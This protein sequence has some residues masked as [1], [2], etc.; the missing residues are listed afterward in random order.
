MPRKTK[1]EIAREKLDRIV[2]IREYLK[3]RWKRP[4]AT[5]EPRFQHLN[6]RYYEP[7]LAEVRKRESYK[8][9]KFDHRAYRAK[10]A[11]T[12]SADMRDA[13]EYYHQ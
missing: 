9:K 2:R 10:C 6:G 1:L 5:I 12:V 13:A 8:N 11:R 4:G 7:L 3:A